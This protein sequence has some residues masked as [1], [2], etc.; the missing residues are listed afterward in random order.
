M[1]WFHNDTITQQLM[2]P[3]Q[4]PK[5]SAWDSSRDGLPAAFVTSHN[6]KQHALRLKQQLITLL[7]YA[8][9]SKGPQTPL[10]GGHQQQYTAGLWADLKLTPTYKYQL[11]T[12]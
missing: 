7:K 1:S 10:M 5:Y 3:D 2:I 11:K 8:A 9:V 4:Q 6:T 12:N